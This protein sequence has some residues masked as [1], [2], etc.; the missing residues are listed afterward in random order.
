MVYKPDLH[1]I[2]IVLIHFPLDIQLSHRKNVYTF[3]HL[4]GYV[5]FV[6]TFNVCGWFC[7]IL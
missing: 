4:I 3:I 5:P 6:G 7:W 1:K 2:Q